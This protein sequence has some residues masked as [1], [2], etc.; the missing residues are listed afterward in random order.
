M[1]KHNAI[2]VISCK[3]GRRCRKV[4]L[5]LPFQQL[6]WKRCLVHLW[7]LATFDHTT[8]NVGKVA[9][10]KVNAGVFVFQLN[11]HASLHHFSI[12]NVH[13]WA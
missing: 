5:W 4:I 6:L 8:V 1:C 7:K 3:V 2:T 11:V 12:V 10:N 13:L 9:F